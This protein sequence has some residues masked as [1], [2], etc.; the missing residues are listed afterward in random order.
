[1]P[2]HCTAAK[3]TVTAVAIAAARPV[4]DGTSATENSPTTSETAAVVPQVEI[5]SLQPTMK[6]GYSPSA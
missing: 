1:M 2:R 4:S 6:P 5:Q 3:T